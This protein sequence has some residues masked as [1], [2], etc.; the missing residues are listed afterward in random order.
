[1]FQNIRSELLKANNDLKTNVESIYASGDGSTSVVAAVDKGSQLQAEAIK[2][3]QRANTLN[4]QILAELQRANA[5]NDNLP[6]SNVYAR[7]G[8]QSG[9]V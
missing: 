9:T 5:I 6:T 4:E 2:E 1:M 8:G 7:N 3:A